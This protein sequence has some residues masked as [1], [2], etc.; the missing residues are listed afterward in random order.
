MVTFV[1]D[2][3]SGTGV[4]EAEIDLS[5]IDIG[6][7]TPVAGQLVNLTTGPSAPLSDTTDGAGDIIFPA[8]TANPTS[9]ADRLLQPVDDAPRAA[10]RCSRTTTSRRRRPRP[11]RTSSWRRRRP[12]RRRSAIYKGSTITVILQNQSTGSTYT[13]NATVTLSTTLRGTPTSQ[14]FAYPAGR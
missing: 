1:S 13:G 9:G 11:T 8:L 4:N 14:N 6:N 5:V 2:V 10:T 3:N 7:N 12:S